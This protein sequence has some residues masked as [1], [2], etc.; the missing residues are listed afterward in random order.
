M[1][2][3]EDLSELRMMPE[4]DPAPLLDATSMRTTDGST[5]AATPSTVPSA[6]DEEPWSMTLEV[7]VPLEEVSA[8]SLSWSYAAAP[9]NPPSVPSTSAARAR[10]TPRFLGLG[11]RGPGLLRSAQRAAG[12]RGGEAAAVHRGRGGGT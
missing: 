12:R 10:P 2:V 8:S 7:V 5:F 9:P 1:L 6:V 4:P 3:G 11:L